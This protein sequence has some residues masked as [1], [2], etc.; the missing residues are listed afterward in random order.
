MDLSLT[1]EQEMLKSMTRDF[2]QRECPKAT[3]LALD[4]TE[5]G[6]SPETWNKAA[7]L[8]WLGMVV[9]E[10]YG[11]G[12]T[13]LTD[14][15]VLFEELGRGPVPGPFFSSGVLSSIVLREAGT[16][17]QRQQM[18]P[19]ICRGEQV[20]TLALAEPDPHYGWGPESVRMTANPGNGGFVLDGT[21][22]FVPDA[23]A[24]D[25]FIC[26]VRTAE[27]SDPAQGI[28][29]LMVDRGSPGISVRN[30][31]GW[32]ARGAEIRFESTEVPASAVL[33]EPG[34]GWPVLE[35]AFEMATP[36]LC[37]YQV[38]GCQ[39]VFDMSVEYSQ[40]RIQFGQPI[41]RFQRVQD[42]I[43]NLVNQLDAARWTT[44]EALWK[45]DSGRPAAASVHLA[46]AVTSTAYHTACLHAHEVHAGTGAT[47]EYGLVLHTR[48]SRT[49][50]DYLGGPD[51]HRQRLADVLEL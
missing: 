5:T 23:M 38:G 25:H 13:C 12:G 34:Q 2:V 6:F 21:K 24:A 47:M 31:S 19:P 3:L 46:K 45:L 28:T 29:L 40:T 50:F 16:E 1:E 37:A 26:A 35:R 36:I 4:K 14:V 15:A 7:A 22:L 10:E 44:N 43:I 18:L 48:T 33:G 32:L 41:G 8:G 30:L 9:P 51:F 39:A 17:E 42:H 11:G 27:S 20:V 49:L